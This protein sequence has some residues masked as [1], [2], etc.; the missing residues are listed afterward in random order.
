MAV[1]QTRER[2]MFVS[3]SLKRIKRLCVS[4]L[5]AFLFLAVIAGSFVVL[6]YPVKYRDIIYEQARVNDLRPSFVYAVIHAESKFRPNATS[7]KSA[8]G[9]MQLTDDTAAWL[10]QKSGM[11]GYDNKHIYDPEVNIAL[12]SFYL[13]MLLDRFDQNEELALAAY[14]AGS[15][16]VSRWLSNEAYT[17]DGTSLKSIPYPE[18]HNFVK[19]VRE[20]ERIYLLLLR[21]MRG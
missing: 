1:A 10:A 3:I 4:A 9:L 8:K 13:R 17:T 15:T 11:T 5:L 20:N 16:N 6:R 21:V 14:N 2:P 7:G 12:G 18:T 19:R